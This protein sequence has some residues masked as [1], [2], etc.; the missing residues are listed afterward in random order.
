MVHEPSATVIEEASWIFAVTSEL[1]TAV[2]FELKQHDRW[3]VSYEMDA[4]TVTTDYRVLDVKR[5]IW[6]IGSLDSGCDVN[7]TKDRCWNCQG[8]QAQVASYVSDVVCL[9]STELSREWTSSWMQYSCS[10]SDTAVH[11]S[12]I[13]ESLR[14]AVRFVRASVDEREEAS[15]RIHHT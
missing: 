10:G 11:G 6:S 12:Q 15:R 13:H 14:V 2:G 4:S 1:V 9:H 5:Q 3:M 8:V 7:F